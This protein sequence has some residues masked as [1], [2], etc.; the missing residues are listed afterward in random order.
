MGILVSLA[1]IIETSRLSTSRA[2]AAMG[3]ELPVIAM[4]VLGGTSIAGGSGTVGGTILGMLVLSYL[5][6]GLEFAGVRNDWSLIVVG[7][8][9][10]LGVFI[11][12]RFRSS[13]N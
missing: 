11:N 8:F 7:G 13:A 12:G 2:N 6:D 1:A 10:I 4:V 3:L 9:L 5:Q